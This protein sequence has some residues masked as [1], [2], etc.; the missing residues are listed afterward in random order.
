MTALAEQRPQTIGELLDV[1]VRLYLRAFRPFTIAL[2]IIS[3]AIYAAGFLGGAEP[4]HSLVTDF[5]A[6]FKKTKTV[7]PGTKALSNVLLAP[8]FILGMLANFIGIVL[9]TTVGF[10]CAVAAVD[11]AAETLTVRKALKCGFTRLWPALGATVVQFALA[12]V[13]AGAAAVIFVLAIGALMRIAPLIA[14]VPM[15]VATVGVYAFL[16]LGQLAWYQSMLAV[17]LDGC[18]AI[19]GMRRGLRLTLAAPFVKRALLVGLVIMLIGFAEILAGDGIGDLVDQIPHAAIFGGFPTTL[20]SI[21][22][23]SIEILFILLYARDVRR[24]TEPRPQRLE[25]VTA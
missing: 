13:V 15:L 3:I 20:L 14:I 9:T 6:L 5:F 10:A 7:P 1:A 18:G 24:R 19:A 25:M 17:T 23:Q 21:P 16:A 8:T 4:H 12:A 11:N 2:G 22:E